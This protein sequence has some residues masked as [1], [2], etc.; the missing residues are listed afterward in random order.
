MKKAVW[1]SFDLGVKGD[2][3]SLWAWLDEQHA[4][5]CVGN[6]AFIN[7]SYKSDLIKSLRDE[8]KKT[9]EVDKR[10]RIYAIWRDEETKKVKGRFLFG[11]RRVSPWAGYGAEEESLEMDE[12]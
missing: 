12:S 2:Y 8:L 7:Y 9:I 1:I 3:E 6:L 4:K 5:E 10:T 11:G